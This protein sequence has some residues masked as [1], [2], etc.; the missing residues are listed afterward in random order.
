MNLT[1]TYL[2]E[3]LMD[4][5]DDCV[6]KLF[7]GVRWVKKCENICKLTFQNALDTTEI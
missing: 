3:Y 6:N 7:C 1:T 4:L 2:G 5:V